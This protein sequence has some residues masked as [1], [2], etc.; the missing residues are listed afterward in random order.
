MRSPLAGTTRAGR[1]PGMRSSKLDALGKGVA[2]ETGS[3]AVAS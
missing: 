1:P 2:W 3:L